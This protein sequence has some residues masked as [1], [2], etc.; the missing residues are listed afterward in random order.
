VSETIS[1]SLSQC[2]TQIELSAPQNATK[3]ELSGIHS[4]RCSC[5]KYIKWQVSQAWWQIWC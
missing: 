2:V 4:H 5:G 3:L 1:Q